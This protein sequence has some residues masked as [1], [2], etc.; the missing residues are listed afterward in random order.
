MPGIEALVIICRT[1]GTETRA[2]AEFQNRCCARDFL[3]RFH[4]GEFDDPHDVDRFHDDGGPPAPE[5]N[6]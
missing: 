6:A 4:A 1:C 3:E 5:R 2:E